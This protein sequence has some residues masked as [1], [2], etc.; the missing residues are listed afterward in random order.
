MHLKC[1]V[2]LLTEF[3]LCYSGKVDVVKGVNKLT[4]KNIYWVNHWNQL[5]CLGKSI[6]LFF[7][8]WAVSFKAISTIRNVLGILSCVIDPTSD[9]FSNVT[10]EFD[11]AVSCF[12][13]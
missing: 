6:S 7:V 2:N 13:N 11:R 8:L 4:T 5:L 10:Y 3:R 9:V 12:S 1:S